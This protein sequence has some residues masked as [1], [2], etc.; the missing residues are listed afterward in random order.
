MIQP[1]LPLSSETKTYLIESYYSFDGR[2]LREVLG[3]K[4][5][6]RARKELDDAHEKSR[7]PIAG[8]RRMFDNLKRIMKRVEDLEGNIFK[9]I[10]ADFL[11]PRQLAELSIYELFNLSFLTFLLLAY[12]FHAIGNYFP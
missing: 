11:L 8:C 7:I 5:S 2:V 1:L 10:Q 12:L 4:L 9:I 3:K 6:S